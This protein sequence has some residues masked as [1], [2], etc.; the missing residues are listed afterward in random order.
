MPL[1]L[2]PGSTSRSVYELRSRFGDAVERHVLA[3]VKAR[4]KAKDD[5]SLEGYDRTYVADPFGNRIE[6]MERVH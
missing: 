1:N 4:V 3:V 2:A 6:L 5:R